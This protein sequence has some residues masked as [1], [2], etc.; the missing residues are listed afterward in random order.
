[1]EAGRAHP[2][3]P[4][5]PIE[6]VRLFQ[7]VV[8]RP[9]G[10]PPVR[11]VR[12]HPQPPLHGNSTNCATL[13]AECVTSFSLKKG[14]CRALGRR[15]SARLHLGPRQGFRSHDG[16]DHVRRFRDYTQRGRHR[17]HDYHYVTTGWPFLL[18]KQRPFI[19][20]SVHLKRAFVPSE[21]LTKPVTLVLIVYETANRHTKY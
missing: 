11:T 8:R 16:A 15:R 4:V 12:G 19:F 21:H 5:G 7:S 20:A 1:M 10:V 18:M 6:N 17:F 13:A 3:H 14:L 2:G 9:S